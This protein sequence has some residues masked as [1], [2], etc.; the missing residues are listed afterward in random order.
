MYPNDHGQFIFYLYSVP[1]AL[2]LQYK[3]LAIAAHLNL[4]TITTKRMALL[5]AYKHI[6]GAAFRRSQFGIDMIKH[7]NKI[8][9]LISTPILQRIVTIPPTISAT[10]E[11]V[12]LATAYGLFTLGELP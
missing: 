4:I 7:H 12:H 1:R 3:L 2:L 10:D 11:C 6:F 8:E 9:E 5:N